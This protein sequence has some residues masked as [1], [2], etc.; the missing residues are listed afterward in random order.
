MKM[1]QPHLASLS[2]QALTALKKLAPLTR[3]SGRAFPGKGP[4]GV[5]SIIRG[6]IAICA[7]LRDGANVS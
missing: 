4:E 7:P 3:K 1:R 6:M 2:T 5:T